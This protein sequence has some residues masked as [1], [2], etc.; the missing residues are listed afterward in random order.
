MHGLCTEH[1]DQRTLQFGRGTLLLGNRNLRQVPPEGSSAAPGVVL[2]AVTPRDEAVRAAGN[3]RTTVH[4]TPWFDAAN[5]AKR[6][7]TGLELLERYQFP[8]ALVTQMAPWHDKTTLILPMLFMQGCNSHCAFCVNSM[9]SIEARDVAAVVRSIAW[10]RETYDVRFFHFLNTNINGYYRYADAFC[11]ALLDAKLDILWSDSLNLR[12]L[13]APLLDKLRR[14]GLIRV[15]VG[16]EAPSDRMLSYIGKGMTVRKAEERLRMLHEAGIWTHV[17]FIAGMPTETEEDI[18][19]YESFVERTAAYSDGFAVSPFYVEPMSLLAREP[20]RFGIELLAPTYESVN[21][22]AFRETAGLGW[23]AKQRQIADTTQRVRRA[24]EKAK[25]PRYSTSALDLDLL[26]WL[27]D[28]L[29]PQRKADIVALYERATWDEPNSPI[30]QPLR[31][32]ST[33]MLR[34]RAV[35]ARYGVTL[36]SVTAGPHHGIVLDLRSAGEPLRLVV[37]QQTDMPRNLAAIGPFAISHLPETPVDS[38][39]RRAGLRVVAAYLR[40]CADR[41]G[42]MVGEATQRAPA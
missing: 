7:Q 37:A 21:G 16:V 28:S 38:A 12:V 33:E 23:D 31:V 8:P 24:I 6:R 11:D 1:N 40:R 18:C 34:D 14:S 13:D 39:H 36:L 25:G 9:S 17:Q 35:L 26:F 10:L 27:Y 5:L 22:G 32:L 30:A 29:G 19:A 20:E 15:A 4:V 41:A 2:P 3:G 42:L